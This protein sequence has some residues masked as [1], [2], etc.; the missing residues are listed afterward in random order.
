M[1]ER[2]MDYNRVSNKYWSYAIQHAVANH[3]HTLYKST[4]NKTLWELVKGDTP[5]IYPYYNFDFY[6]KVRHLH[7]DNEFPKNT[8]LPGRFLGISWDIGGLLTYRILPD[9]PDL[10]NLFALTRSVV[11]PDDVSNL[12]CIKLRNLLST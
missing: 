5:D 10:G 1:N 8:I 11:D 7:P 2:L 6:Q 12:R 9:T 3:N 4:N